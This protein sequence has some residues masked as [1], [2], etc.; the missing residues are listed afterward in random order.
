MTTALGTA[1]VLA[2][3]AYQVLQGIL[4]VGDLLVVMAYIA[5]V[6]K[7]LEAITYTLGSIQNQ[8]VQLRIA[9]NLLDK[10]PEVKQTVQAV[11]ITD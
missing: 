4:T 9:F 5:A 6:Y 7:P 3:G 8:M 2:Y 1:A 11:E 10:E